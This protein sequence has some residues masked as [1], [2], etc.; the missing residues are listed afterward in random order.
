MRTICLLIPFLLAAQATAAT[1]EVDRAD[2][3]RKA[4]SNA[5]AGETIML[6]AG[7]YDIADLKLRRDITL[8]GEGR[9]VLFSSGP[10]A[11]GLLNPLPGA[12]LR[13]ENI[14]FEGARSPDDNGAGIRHDGNN[15]TVVNC[16]FE[17]NENG[18]LATGEETGRIRIEGSAFIGNGH[19]DGYSH[20]IYVSSGGELEI[21]NSKFAGTK[22]GHHVKSLA[23]RTVIRHSVLDDAGGRTSYAVDASKG[24]DVTIESSLVIQSADSE[25]AAI[26]NY[27]LTR[28]G[29]AIAL[30]IAGNRIVNRHPGGVILRNATDLAP[31][32][33]GNAVVNEGRG[34][35]QPD[36]HFP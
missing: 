21:T 24:G 8:I 34:R 29:A 20:G 30:R 35:L 10:V 1:I 18:I 27:D 28:G 25:N 3:L 22:I 4:V 26:F 14:A 5:R 32:A 2:A 36:P 6:V 7:R 33:E 17:D 9:V 15:L 13:V 19:G 11:K 31:F 23:G 16:L 12:S